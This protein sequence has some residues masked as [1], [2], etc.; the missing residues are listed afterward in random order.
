MQLQTDSTKIKKSKPVDY[1]TFL[2]L[3]QEYIS[4]NYASVLSEDDK[5][6]ELMS[7]IEHFYQNSEYVVPGINVAD[8]GRKLY[9]DMAEY[10]VLTELLNGSRKDIEEINLNSFEDI[11][12]HTEK[13][14]VEKTGL[15]FL[16]SSNAL[17]VV[18]RMLH[19][20]GMIL[21]MS[22][23]MV[24][25]YLN[26]NIRITTIA[27][28]LVDHDI[29]VAASIRIVNP[30]KLSLED[31]I[32]SNTATKEMLLFLCN[33][34]KYGISMCM[35][36]ST[37]SGKTTLMS[38]ILSTV[39]DDMRIVTIE[40]GVR[41]FDLVKKDTS[42]KTVSNVLHLC[43]KKAD[44]ESECVTSEMLV[45]TSLTLNPDIICVA[46]M[47]D[48]EAWAAQEA[49]RTGHAVITTVH[50][51][52]AEAT[53]ARMCTLCMLKHSVDYSIVNTLVRDA[54]PIV[55]Y[56]KKLQD[57]SRHVMKIIECV[58][59]AQGDSQINILWRYVI[60]SNTTNSDGKCVIDGYYER[61]NH[62]SDNLADRL[63]ENGMPID[64]I[65]ELKGEVK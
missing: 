6:D 48:Q 54:F 20:S 51:N 52:S 64:L 19:K 43:T 45:S 23:P 39:P 10:S 14:T 1:A 7:Y 21:D 49:A 24:R 15:R 28:P 8:L 65:K 63:L 34:L 40:E 47:K 22:K 33:I 57:N 2:K 27:P 25:G 32:K 55:I 35:T 12:I 58:V 13:G 59:N 36:G 11:T 41:E 56:T 9:T 44:K 29:G 4:K 42:G 61:V 60:T 62:I 30:K 38:W 37:G 3:T 53:Y 16:N 26:K 17:D 18:K 31:F 50:A 5:A 46:E